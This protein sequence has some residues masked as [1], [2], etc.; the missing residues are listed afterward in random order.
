MHYQNIRLNIFFFFANVRK[1]EGFSHILLMCYG[2][3]T[4]PKIIGLHVKVF[5]NWTRPH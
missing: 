3:S 5:F 2:N 4:E 1:E